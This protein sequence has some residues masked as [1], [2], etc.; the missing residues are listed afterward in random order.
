[1]KWYEKLRF[2]RKIKGKT[3]RQTES[4]TGYSNSYLS[5]LETGKIDQ[6]GFFLIMGLLKYYN[7]KTEDIFNGKT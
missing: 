2:A 4:E 6:P 1:M 3:L 5:Q 7:L